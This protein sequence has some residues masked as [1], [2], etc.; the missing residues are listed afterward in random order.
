MNNYVIAVLANRIQAEEAY[1]ALEKENLPMD[2]ASILGKGYKSADEFG[3]TD[4]KRDAFKK[5]KLMGF[6]LVPFG[7]VAGL[8]FNASTQFELFSWA[9]T[10]GNRLIGGLLGAIGGAM[11]SFFV[12]GG[13]GLV[14][15]GD[16]LSY[17]NLLKQGRYVIVVN[18]APNVTNKATRILRSFQPESIQTQV[19]LQQ[20]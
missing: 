17:Q 3:L 15:S 14:S 7:F 10:A 6:W 18:G 9:G 20:T 12:G 11:G 5:A 13:I 19:D 4:P 8:A 1:S 16:T 2:Q